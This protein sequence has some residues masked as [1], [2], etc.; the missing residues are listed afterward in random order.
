[1]TQAG[2]EK[3]A[4]APPRT[5]QAPRPLDRCSMLAST[6][7]SSERDFPMRGLS[8]WGVPMRGVPMRGLPMRG[9]PM[10]GLSMWGVP[11]CGVPMRGVPMHGVPM[12]GLSLRGL[13]LRGLSLRNKTHACEGTVLP[14][15]QCFAKL[16]P[17]MYLPSVDTRLL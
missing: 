16:S 1:M 9:V 8:M 15:T 7:C 5:E 4:A 17:S 3:A 6:A 12:R 10:R 2:A 11:M 14:A 13:S